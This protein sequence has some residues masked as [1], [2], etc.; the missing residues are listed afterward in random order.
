[1]P[2]IGTGGISSGLDAY[3]KVRAGAS[4]LQL[5]TAYIYN[6][7]AGVQNILAELAH[8][9]EKDGFKSLQEAVGADHHKDEQRAAATAQ[10]AG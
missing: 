1:M 5:Y 10:Q 2:L 6:G 3:L 4:L 7:A 9:L 8:L